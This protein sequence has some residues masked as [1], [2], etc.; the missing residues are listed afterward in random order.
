[1][2][3]YPFEKRL[4]LWR[5]FRNGLETSENPIQDTVDF[6]NSVPLVAIQADPYNSETWPDP[7]Q[8][9]HEN[10]F[11]PFVKILAICYTLQLTER[12]SHKSFEIHITQDIEKSETKYLLLVDGLCIGYDHS[13]II[14]IDKI[15]NDITIEKTYTMP[16][17]Q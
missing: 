14:S 11:C 17:L 12:F 8:I 9:I 13:K 2:F 15:T 3:N 16:S 10:I 7:W 6:W 4:S 1:M 5:D